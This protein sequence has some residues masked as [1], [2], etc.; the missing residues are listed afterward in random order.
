MKLKGNK[1]FSKRKTK[2]ISISLISV[3]IVLFIAG[4]IVCYIGSKSF[5]NYYV[6]RINMDYFYTSLFNFISISLTY[7]K[8]YWIGIAL[9]VLSASMLVGVV[10]IYVYCFETYKNEDENL[11]KVLKKINADGHSVPSV[12]VGETYQ[13]KKE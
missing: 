3:G 6:E 5:N 2:W 1:M 12:K 7:S 11:E 13:N 8:L 10:V 9:I 4:I